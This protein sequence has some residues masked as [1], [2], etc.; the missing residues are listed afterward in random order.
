MRFCSTALNSEAVANRYFSVFG[1][2]L[3]ILAV[4][5]WIFG[6]RIAQQ[7][8]KKDNYKNNCLK[9][10]PY[11]I[12]VTTI[13]SCFFAASAGYFLLYATWN[14]AIFFLFGLAGYLWIMINTYCV[15][16]SFSEEGILYRA[17]SVK[18][19]IPFSDILKITWESGHRSIDYIL[20]IYCANGNKF[21]FSS[22]D[23]VGLANLKDFFETYK[24]PAN[25]FST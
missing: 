17:W 3:V 25:E 21:R 2:M 5:L 9:I 11:S 19:S 22:R 18:K 13:I 16:V 23:F 8:V 20:V 14:M 7:L 10:R 6:E 24:S 1:P 4:L 12:V 15:K